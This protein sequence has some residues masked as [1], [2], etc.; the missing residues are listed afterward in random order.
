V[1]SEPA[2]PNDAV[3]D[4]FAAL[5]ASNAAQA[6]RPP[7]TEEEI[8]FQLQ[9]ADVAVRRASAELDEAVSWRAQL[10]RTAL[11]AGLSPAEALRADRALAN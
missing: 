5:A 8:L 11:A 10:M 3:I 2:I 6:P 9:A 7:W 4:R 1:H